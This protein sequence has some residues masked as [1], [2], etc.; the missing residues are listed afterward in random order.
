MI[1]DPCEIFSL[2]IFNPCRKKK[3][4]QPFYLYLLQ[5]GNFAV[6]IPPRPDHPTEKGRIEAAGGSVT[7][8][9]CKC[10]VRLDKD[11]KKQIYVVYIFYIQYTQIYKYNYTLEYIQ[12]ILV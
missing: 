5:W 6:I 10:N 2:F 12:T 9:D 4:H 1:A 7:F 8:E 3:P 11:A